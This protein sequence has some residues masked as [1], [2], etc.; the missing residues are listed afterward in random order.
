M[1]K[2]GDENSEA[3]IMRNE[4]SDRNSSKMFTIET[5]PLL[6]R[7]SDYMKSWRLEVLTIA[8]NSTWKNQR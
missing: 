8:E 4:G 5:M 7:K 2:V 1:P 6:N 3:K